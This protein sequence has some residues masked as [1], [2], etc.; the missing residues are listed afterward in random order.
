MNR[1]KEREHAA[2]TAT[3][4]AEHAELMERINQIN[5][6]RESN[7]LLRSEAS[8]NKQ[9]VSQLESELS[10][11]STQME[12][13]KQRL[14]TAEASVE[15]CAAQ[16][17]QSRKESLHWQE[18]NQQILSKVSFYN[19]QICFFT[20]SLRQYDRVDPAELQNLRTQLEEATR[21][22]E[23]ESQRVLAEAENV[24][25]PFLSFECS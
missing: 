8:T 5:L 11:L 16:L 21:K 13:L 1:R 9:R 23:E 12:P 24:S 22:A 19:L 2:Q 10:S 7:A 3:S 20:E 6:L 4:A 17:E 25:F 15:A 18:R 14:L